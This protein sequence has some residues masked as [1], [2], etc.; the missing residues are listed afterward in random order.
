[1]A[2]TATP[3]ATFLQD[4]DSPLAPREFFASL[5]TP[6][7]EG[8][9]EQRSPTYRVPEGARAWY[10]GGEVYYR[11]LSHLPVC[12]TFG[13]EDDANEKLVD[14]VRGY[15]LASA[16]RAMRAPGKAGPASARTMTFDSAQA[17]K[18]G[19]VGPM[20]MLVHPSSAKEEHFESAA[21]VLAWAAGV[22]QEAR[23]GVA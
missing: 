20:S 10:T 17:A 4:P 18:E 21:R 9:W 1:M 11:T 23:T 3:Q 2:Y 8:D 14:A 19:V 6:G 5:R 15:L 12:E 13:P 16:L 7:P 22:D